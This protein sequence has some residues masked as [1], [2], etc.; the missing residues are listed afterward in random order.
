MKIKEVTIIIDFKIYLY[1]FEPIIRFL[2]ING[3]KVYIASSAELLNEI[4]IVLNDKNISYID[5]SIIK[6][7]KIN[8]FR[9]GL[10]RASSILFTREDFSFQFQK[11]R[12]Q[13]TKKFSGLQGLLLK[14]ARFTPKVPNDKINSFLHKIASFGQVN[15]FP[16][17]HVIVGSLNASAELLCSKGIKVI[18]VME[19]WDH[20]VKEPNGYKSDI[21]LGWNENLCDDW[22]RVQG[23]SDCIIF[24]PLKLRYGHE[25]FFW[26]APKN[27]KKRLLYPAASTSKFSIGILVNIEKKIIEELIVF[28]ANLGWELIIKPRPNGL[29][30]EFDEYKKNDNVVIGDVSHSQIVNPANYFYTDSDN[31][32]RFNILENVDMVINAFTTYGLD[33]AVAGLPVLQLD[34][35]N[36]LGFEDSY[37]VYNNYHIKNYLISSTSLLKPQNISLYEALMKSEGQLLNTASSYSSEIRDWLYYYPNSQSAIETCFGKILN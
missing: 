19:S 10:H 3:V 16:T 6:N 31:Y 5:Y 2:I 21:F 26:S 8:K 36:T 4:K 28:T 35:R 14:L 24:H 17:K 13:T 27:K 37:M 23:D 7:T 34:L 30:G 33:A 1:L 12:Q 20:A 22:K 11:K 32:D 9:Y 15:P 25:K 29:Y 18:T